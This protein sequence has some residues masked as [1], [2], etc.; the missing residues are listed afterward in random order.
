VRNKKSIALA[1]ILDFVHIHMYNIN[2][3]TLYLTSIP[4]KKLII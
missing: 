4:I 1:S 2:K 3:I